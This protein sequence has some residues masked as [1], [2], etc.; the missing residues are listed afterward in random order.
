MYYT[1]MVWVIT[2]IYLSYLNITSFV[3]YYDDYYTQ[4]FMDSALL[5]ILYWRILIG[6]KEN[7]SNFLKI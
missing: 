7:E 1:T 6:E 3:Q 5:I 2:G 4:C